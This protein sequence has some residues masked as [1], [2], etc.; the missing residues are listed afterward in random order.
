MFCDLGIQLTPRLSYHSRDKHD[1]VKVFINHSDPYDLE[2]PLDTDDDKPEEPEEADFVVQRDLFPEYSSF[3]DNLTTMEDGSPALYLGGALDIDH[4]IFNDYVN[5]L[6]RGRIPL[7][8]TPVPR[9][10]RK[11][12]ES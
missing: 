9:R 6:H 11:R 10:K 7:V 2:T 5:W 1:M 8:E 12:R 3:E 4:G